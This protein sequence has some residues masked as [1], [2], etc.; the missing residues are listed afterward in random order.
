M[1]PRLCSS[2]RMTRSGKTTLYFE[3]AIAKFISFLDHRE[4]TPEAV[5]LVLND[6]ERDSIVK[7]GYG[8]HSF[9]HSLVET[10]EKL[11]V[12]PVTPELA[13][14][15]SQL[16]PPDCRSSDGSVARRA[17]DFAVPGRAPPLDHDDEG[18]SCRAVGK[19]GAIGIE[20]IFFGDRNRGGE[21]R[22]DLP[23]R[24]REVWASRPIRHGWLATARSP[25]SIPHSRRGCTRS[26]YRMT[27][28]GFWSMKNW[29]VHLY[30]NG[31]W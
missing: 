13:R 16:C 15:H 5:R 18:E 12:D 19:S 23:L 17:R 22:S 4:H 31:C 9:A 1:G 21:G 20:G 29:Q 3:R 26:S 30:L 6:V 10:F 7:H 25:I 28:R 11:S 27:R 2:M 24:N 14:A 8:L